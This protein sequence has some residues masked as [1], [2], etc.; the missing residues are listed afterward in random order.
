[1]DNAYKELSQF[2]YEA[3]L[4]YAKSILERQ[5]IEF[6]SEDDITFKLFVK[7]EQYTSA[8]NIVNTLQ[9]D[10]SDVSS[11]CYGYINGYIEWIDN[12]YV[13]GYFT[14]GNIPIW[15]YGKTYAQF[16]GP[17]ILITGVYYIAAC[18]FDGNNLLG[19][20]IFLPH[21]YCGYLLI[22]K[23]LKKE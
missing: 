14:G 8:L 1:M 20:L 16:Y 11:E 6:K 23:G 7:A 10:E 18:I 21:L 15:M 19:T 12:Q 9:L 5:N 3:N 13:S 17:I 4:L 2:K 22:L